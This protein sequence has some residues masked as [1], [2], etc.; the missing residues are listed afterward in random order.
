MVGI[1]EF[2]VGIGAFFVGIGEFWLVLASFSPNTQKKVTIYG[3]FCLKDFH[4]NK[5]KPLVSDSGI[6]KSC[7]VEQDCD[8]YKGLHTLFVLGALHNPQLIMS[9]AIFWACVV[10]LIYS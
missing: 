10:I 5:N 1:S 9:H 3:Y 4:F 8:L 7:N 6:W 2:L